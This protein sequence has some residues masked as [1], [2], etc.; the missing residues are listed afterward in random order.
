MTWSRTDTWTFHPPTELLGEKVVHARSPEDL[1]EGASEAKAIRKPPDAV[2]RAKARFKVALAI[3][4][5]SCEAL[6]GWHVCVVFN[7]RSTNCIEL[8]LEHLLTHALEE[9]G[10]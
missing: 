1:R 5:L 9:R 7:P 6:T 10:V 4:K 2:P 3:D 8:A